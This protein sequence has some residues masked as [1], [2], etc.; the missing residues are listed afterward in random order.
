MST[1]Q[2]ALI[3]EPTGLAGLSQAEA[4]RRLRQDGP[5]ELPQ[6]EGRGLLH[7]A[8]EVLREPMILLLLAAGATARPAAAPEPGRS[9]TTPHLVLRRSRRAWPRRGSAAWARRS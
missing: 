2:P 8:L 6:R 5:N 7:T 1:Q 3:L 9:A 4:H